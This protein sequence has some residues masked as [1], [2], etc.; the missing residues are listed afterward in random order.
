MNPYGVIYDLRSTIYERGGKGLWDWRGFSNTRDEA[1]RAKGAQ[2]VTE[3][4]SRRRL[5]HVGSVLAC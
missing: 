5:D 4:L 2:C 3:A 1:R